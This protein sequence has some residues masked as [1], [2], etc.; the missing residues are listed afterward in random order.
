[1]CYYTSGIEHGAPRNPLTMR[2]DFPLKTKTTLAKRVGMH[3]SN[4]DCKQLTSGPQEDPNE[5]ISIGVAAHISA[6][7]VGGP[8]YN[9]DMTAQE[10]RSIRNGI[11]LCQNCAKLIDSDAAHYTVD[12][13][14]HWKCTSEEATRLQIQRP[15]RNRSCKD[16]EV[17]GVEGYELIDAIEQ[18][19]T[20]T[21]DIERSLEPIWIVPADAPDRAHQIEGHIVGLP[22]WSFNEAIMRVHE[23]LHRARPWFLR[24]GFSIGETERKIEG[25]KLAI[26]LTA[27]QMWMAA[28]VADPQTPGNQVKNVL[29]S[30]QEWA[31]VMGMGME[32]LPRIL[33]E[34]RD[35]MASRKWLPRRP[36]TVRQRSSQL[37]DK[38]ILEVELAD[39]MDSF[40]TAALDMKACGISLRNG[41]TLESCLRLGALRPVDRE[42]CRSLMEAFG[43]CALMLSRA[44]KLF[45]R[46]C[47]PQWSTDFH[48]GISS[49]VSRIYSCALYGEEDNHWDADMKIIYAASRWLHREAAKEYGNDRMRS[50][51]DLWGW[52][53][54]AMGVDP[55]SGA[56]IPEVK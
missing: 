13:L 28:L 20:E 25:V 24:L 5:T 2:D 46:L 32:L 12:L 9:P 11:W 34:L 23:K 56:P 54:E 42:R 1:M 45:W 33:V 29:G 19:I 37:G 10:R 47:G 39:A 51:S 36:H 30:R 3:C 16:I 6:A 52:I 8:R 44:T 50:G 41:P 7:S 21:L 18:F 27:G 43:R 26:G 31:P 4:P 15:L 49:I 22:W 40:A 48:R 35:L 38:D 17:S 14:H 55:Q 53:A